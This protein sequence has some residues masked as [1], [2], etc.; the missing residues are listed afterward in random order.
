MDLIFYFAISRSF[1]LQLLQGRAEA[2]G[3]QME[4]N[5]RGIDAKGIEAVLN[6]SNGDRDLAI[7]ALHS[8]GSDNE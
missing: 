6:T 4:R 1:V 3:K 2:Y 8:L 5:S 7:R